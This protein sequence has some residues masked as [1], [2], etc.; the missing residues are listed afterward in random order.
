MKKKS[1]KPTESELEIL[2]ILWQNGP[3]T[4]RMVNENLNKEKKVG[5]TTTLKM[6]QIMFEKNLVK[7]NEDSR[8]HIY[9]ANVEEA[10]IQKKMLDNFLDKTFKGSAG[11]LIMQALGNKK[12]SKQ[13]LNEIKALIDKLENDDKND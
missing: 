4:V 1:T 7:R 3:S 10:D 9:G 5:Y 13:E 2:Q 6:L 8:S 11:K 12:T